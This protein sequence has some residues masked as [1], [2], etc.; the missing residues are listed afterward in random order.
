MMDSSNKHKR[1]IPQTLRRRALVS[2][3]R[4]KKRR[5]R[6]LRPPDAHPEDAC[7]SCLVS[8]VKCESTLPRKHRI[9]GSVETL[10]L[11][12]RAL[13]A[14]VKGLFP[15]E[16]TEVTETLFRLAEA[17]GIPMPSADDHT[18]SE[19]AL[20][21]WPSV[22][23][24]P[25]TGYSPHISIVASSTP[26]N[27]FVSR[28]AKIAEEKLIPAPHGVSHYIGPSSSFGFAFAVRNMVAERHSALGQYRPDHAHT[29]LQ[30]D[31]AGLR[32]SQALEPQAAEEDISLDEEEDEPE[33][34]KVVAGQQERESRS[35]DLS[36]YSA[37]MG[38]GEPTSR[39]KTVLASFL[40]SREVADALVEAFFQ[41][42]H[43]N[44]LLFHRGT[45]QLRYES[46]WSPVANHVPEIELGWI[47]SIFMVFVFGAQALEHH[48]K[49]Q[50][51]CLKRRYLGLVQSRL[52]HLINTT[53]LVNIQ[54]L[55]L[56]QLLQHNSSERNASWMLLGC[57]S[58]MAIALGMHREGATGG[59]DPV[60]KEVRR[61]VWWTLYMFEQNLSMMLG[62]P[63]AIDDVEVNVSIPN[64]AMLDGG[65]CVPPEYIDYSLR[66]TR[67]ASVIKRT[68]YA[69]PISRLQ[70][71]ELPRTSVAK[72]LLLDLESWYHSLPSHLCV[73]GDS[74]APKQRRAVLLLHINY[75]HTNALVTRPYLLRKVRLE[76]D[77]QL[78]LEQRFPDIDADGLALAHSCSTSSREAVVLLHQLATRGMLDGVAWLDTFYAYH[79]VLVLSLDFL[80]RPSNVE[81]SPEDLMRKASVRDVVDVLCSTKLCPTFHIL[82]QV[83]VQF[84]RIVGILDDASPTHE[85]QDASPQSPPQQFEP[86]AQEDIAGIIHEWFQ[87]DCMDVPWDFFELGGYGGIQNNLPYQ[88]LTPFAPTFGTAYAGAGGED[89][90]GTEPFMSPCNSFANWGNINDVF[91]PPNLQVG[92]INRHL[93]A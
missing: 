16:N 22:C 36:P 13:D 76:L 47:C 69:A 31:F 37:S 55:L 32:T 93:A 60:E 67:I 39:K 43:P 8:G 77:R 90:F 26:D 92:G 72:Q 29:A 33:F 54:A 19:H 9:Y 2:C 21:E 51:V 41:Q 78:R 75:Y 85:E 88:P 35:P 57:A 10:S 4:C 12:Y 30:S 1:R 24:S 40:P 87:Q 46:I 68:I 34:E 86:K 3:D 20:N 28:A 48:D 70:Q 27:P 80:V 81:D 65:D 45:F 62:R 89:T 91:T 50:A 74:L 79:G 7:Q 63:S 15:D 18:P 6:C 66:L 11:R 25:M 73:E 52:H 17:R 44:Y 42:V 49:Q 59:F 53:S 56:L 82:A 5:V 23:P 61:R 64:E 84:A 83:A 14:L 38:E 71:D 58:R